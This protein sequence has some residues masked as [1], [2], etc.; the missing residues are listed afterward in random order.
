MFGWIFRVRQIESVHVHFL[1]VSQDKHLLTPFSYHQFPLLP[2]LL[3]LLSQA[4][5]YL[6][7]II[8]APPWSVGNLHC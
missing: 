2:I 1:D 3:S 5:I 6:D 7:P 4:C 8:K